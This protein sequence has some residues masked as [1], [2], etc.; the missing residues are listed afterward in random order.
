MSES[1]DLTKT[2]SCGA[3]LSCAPKDRGKPFTCPKCK[4]IHTY[5]GKQG[6]KS[7]AA[8][9]EGNSGSSTFTSI[10]YRLSYWFRTVFSFTK[11]IGNRS[12]EPLR[13]NV[14]EVKSTLLSSKIIGPLQS[15]EVPT[16]SAP[17][18]RKKLSAEI[19]QL[20][21]ELIRRSWHRDRGPFHLPLSS[22]QLSP[23]N[24]S[25]CLQQMLKHAEQVAPKLNIPQMIP[26]IKFEDTIL[27]QAGGTFQVKGDG[28][29]FIT[30]QRALE[31]Q[32]KVALAV[33]SHELCH[34]I[35]GSNNIRKQPTLENEK[36]TDVCMFVLGFGK[37]FLE[38]FQSL[39]GSTYGYL[40]AEEYRALSLD[41]EAKWLSRNTAKD[42]DTEVEELEKW[43]LTAL[44]H[45]DR[46]RL[47][48]IYRRMRAKYP[49]WS[50]KEI[51]EK[52]K[53]DF[54]R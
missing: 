10:W 21:N 39:K 38:G 22:A 41:V 23:P 30:V 44:A 9:E 29:V 19:N 35:L 7:T 6:K 45:G 50:R 13:N 5:P 12:N 52:L 18:N 40:Q 31:Q 3:V 53:Y 51:L 25:Q 34:Y 4:R 33:L 36:M 24:W 42:I 11:R 2:Y 37:L 20:K 46:S 32:P 26:D 27:H 47:K 8:T 15:G 54:M 43:A 1:K 48:F 16:F 14:L 28:R 17:T 49:G